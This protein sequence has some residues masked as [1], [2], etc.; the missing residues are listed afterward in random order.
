MSEDAELIRGV[1]LLM[2][3]GAIFT[4]AGNE[5]EKYGAVQTLDLASFGT[6]FMNLAVVLGVVVVIAVVV[7]PIL[8]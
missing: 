6:I 3:A 7:K 8:D 1:L 4:L 5:L 2:V